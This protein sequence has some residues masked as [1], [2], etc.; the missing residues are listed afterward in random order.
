VFTVKFEYR[1][2]LSNV[3]CVVYPDLNLDPSNRFV[4]GP[5]GSGSGFIVTRFDPD[6]DPSVKSKNTKKNFDAYC[7][8][9]FFYFLSC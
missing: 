8:E 4:F 9:P 2:K 6:P 7:F 5:P 3:I 1:V